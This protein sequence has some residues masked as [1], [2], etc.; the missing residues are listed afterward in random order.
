MFYWSS[1]LIVQGTKHDEITLIESRGT[2]L[3]DTIWRYSLDTTVYI[4]DTTLLA[5]KGFW[6]AVQM[7][8]FGSGTQTGLGMGIKP[9]LKLLWHHEINLFVHRF[10]LGIIRDRV[11]L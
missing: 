4:L 2:M 6:N 7:C 11:Y 10:Y 5:W 1:V 9:Y 3:M 8:W